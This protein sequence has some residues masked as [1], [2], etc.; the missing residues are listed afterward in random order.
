MIGDGV[1]FGELIGG[2]GVPVVRF[3]GTQDF[4][5][6]N[7]HRYVACHY[8]ALPVR[9]LRPLSSASARSSALSDGGF[10]CNV[11]CVLIARYSR[12]I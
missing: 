1:P 6:L 5:N 11:P 2:R 7:L 9:W 4:Q 12:I 8:R 3:A 10:S